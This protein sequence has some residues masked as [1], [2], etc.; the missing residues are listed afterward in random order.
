MLKKILSAFGMSATSPTNWVLLVRS[1][2][3]DATEFLEIRQNASTIWTARGAPYNSG[4]KQLRE[5]QTLEE[6]EAFFRQAISENQAQGLNLVHSGRSI[7]G[8]L[9][10]ELLEEAVHD[11]AREAY[12]LICSEHHEE[13]ISGFSLFTD[14]D[15]M[16]ICPAAMSQ[17][18]FADIDDEKDYYLTNP[19]EWPYSNDAGLL[20]AYR[21]IVVAAYEHHDIPF[22][23]EIPG[24]FEQFS[25][26]RI[27]AL[28]R[29]DNSGLFG[30]GIYR[31]RFLLLFGVSDGG[32]TK[33]AVKR[34]NPA[35]VYQRYEH[36]FDD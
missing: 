23:I 10:F 22:E 7:P 12:Q 27:R 31:E 34:L 28:E 2:G 21:I 25:E 32:P 9:D 19:C 11:G 5:F 30:S 26:T 36:C 35:S 20:L 4:E 6:A 18:S 14:F 15:G 17:A 3:S 8:K 29:L 13:I 24:Y 1:A 16:T 33:A